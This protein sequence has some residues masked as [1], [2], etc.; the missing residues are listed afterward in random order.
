MIHVVLF[1]GYQGVVWLKP[2]FNS[3]PEESI[4][5]PSFSKYIT[6]KLH[7]CYGKSNQRQ[8][9]CLFNRLVK[10]IPMKHQIPTVRH[11]GPVRK[12]SF[13]FHEVFTMKKTAL[14]WRHNERN[15]VSNQRRLY[16]LL[17]CWFRRRSKKHQSP[18]LWP[19]WGELTGH[20]WIPRTKVPVTQKMFPFDDVTMVP[21]AEWPHAGV[22]C[23]ISHS[24]LF[25]E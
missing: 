24:I 12:K 10:Q 1:I 7:G 9:D 17:N 18:R 20:R 6:V 11:K 3:N 23:K 19:L 13:P 15:G 4:M 5:I 22:L 8:L 2:N 25:I 16:C 14:Q 21:L